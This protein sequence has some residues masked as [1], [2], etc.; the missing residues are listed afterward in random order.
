MRKCI[1]QGLPISSNETSTVCTYYPTGS[2]A[3]WLS[4]NLC[5]QPLTERSNKKQMLLL[6]CTHTETMR[7]KCVA[8][9]VRTVLD[10]HNIDQNGTRILRATPRWI[11]GRDTETQRFLGKNHRMDIP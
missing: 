9:V 6:V 11:H 1:R 2:Q 8:Y 5:R 4:L 7:A 3:N 10:V